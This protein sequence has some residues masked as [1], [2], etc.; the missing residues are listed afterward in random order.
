[1]LLLLVRR[2]IKLTDQE[3]SLIN[4]C[5]ESHKRMI[6]YH[7]KQIVD[8]SRRMIEEPDLCMECFD[9]EIINESG[10]SNKD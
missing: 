1:M 3:K 5:V 10:R 6:A 4:A 9:F 8:L 2:I 7:R